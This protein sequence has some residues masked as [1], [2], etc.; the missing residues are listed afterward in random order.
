M[1]R[2]VS[3][4]G[5][6]VIDDTP[7]K[8]R[9]ISPRKRNYIVG[10]SALGVGV[11]ALGLVY[12]FA[13]T[14][15]LSDYQNMKYISYSIN[16]SPDEDGPFKGQVTATI[17]SVD[18][19]SGYPSDF[20]I[21]TKINGHIITRIE[22]T[23]FQGC[24]RLTKIRMPNTITSIGEKAFINCKKL[25]TISFSK[26]I[27]SIGNSAFDGTLYKENW[28]NDDVTY[29]NNILLAINEDKILSEYGAS[30]IVLVANAESQYISQYSDSLVF[31][32]DTFSV[33]NQASTNTAEKH[34][35]QWMEGS[36]KNFESL[37]FVEVPS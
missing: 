19:E 33:L 22:D 20:L 34:I 15:W 28:K 12:Y 36:F 32:L 10:L 21:P 6:D 31:S 17:D 25:K 23:A 26:N 29:V 2:L 18:A 37:K 30:S 16:S 14:N 5:A 7:Q 13:T 27:T 11:I 4:L 9:K 8:P 35:T 24:S 3:E 1:S